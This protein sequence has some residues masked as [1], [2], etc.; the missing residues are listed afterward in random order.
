MGAA[1]RI[2]LCLALA[3][4]LATPALPW[5]GGALRDALL[6]ASP[7]DAAGL[8]LAALLPLGEGP[9]SQ[10]WG[11]LAGLAGLG[12]LPSAPLLARP[13]WLDEAPA[14]LVPGLAELAAG[15][16]AARWHVAQALGGLS[17]GD[18][19]V[20]VEG[21]PE[22]RAAA[23]ALAVG[24]PHDAAALR[25]H[26]TLAARVGLAHLAA[27]E[28]ALLRA[29]E[30]A[31]PLLRGAAAEPVP[32]AHCASGLVVF[33]T[34]GCEVVVGG[35]G[36]NAYTTSPALLVDQGGSDA[37]SGSAGGGFLGAA[38]LLDLGTSA[39]TYAS[40]GVAPG[41]PAQG[42][43]VLG[44]GLLVDEGGDDTYLATGALPGP[45]GRIAAQGAGLVGAGVLWD[46]GGND[47]YTSRNLA[48]GVGITGLGLL[49]DEGGLDSYTIPSTFDSEGG[50]GSG[51]VAGAGALVDRGPGAD[52]YDAAIDD[53]QGFG[54][55][56]G[57]G[58]LWDG[59]GSD[60]YV[61]R[62]GPGLLGSSPVQQSGWGQGYGELA[63]AG[64]LLDLGGDDTY[65]VEVL[66]SLPFEGFHAQG[67]GNV[68]SA[69]MLL[70]L[71]GNDSR[72]ARTRA[73]GWGLG[74]LGVLLDAAGN[75]TYAASLECQGF[76]TLGAGALLDLG[77]GKDGY[78]C[79]E[80]TLP[81]TRGDD[82][83]WRSGV[84]GAGV[85]R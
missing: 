24:L 57:L 8:A 65:T 4:A 77:G 60:A 37:Y 85:D 74:G 49:L 54:C 13:P 61:I 51:C 52:A 71:A 64:L 22:A 2:A 25:A 68:G 80:P 10:A 69:G 26:E 83:V 41:Q 44:A 82:Q 79:G 17:Q 7:E 59:G 27:A 33:E 53:L 39:D 36:A 62:S 31:M 70:D 78:V 32:E 19:Q 14:P 43:G 63:A 1:C 6:G 3:P 23:R 46:Q 47:T 84:V 15:L 20:L 48:Q 66:S 73:Q 81:G 75:D 55:L 56:G 50:Q 9:A 40:L 72:A 11:R 42:A 12:T 18:L 5:G 16:G 30:R 67:A 35:T 76:G 58:L 28:L 38:A 29:A 45:S 34:A 21:Y